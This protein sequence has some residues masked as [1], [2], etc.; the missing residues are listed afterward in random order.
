QTYLDDIREGFNVLYESE[1]L[2]LDCDFK[3]LEDWRRDADRMTTGTEIEDINILSGF[4]PSLLLLKGSGKL[5]GS[6]PAN[7]TML[8]KA[9]R[10]FIEN[11]DYEQVSEIVSKQFILQFELFEKA[12]ERDITLFFKH[13][14]RVLNEAIEEAQ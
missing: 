2:N 7:K 4:K 5:L 8:Y 3:I 9:Y 12:I 6:L 11:G 14:F 13:P 10:K 1:K